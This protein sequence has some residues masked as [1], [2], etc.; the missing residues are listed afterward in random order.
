MTLVNNETNKPQQQK[1][2]VVKIKKR[3]TINTSFSKKPH[4]NVS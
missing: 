4:M 2:Q 3:R 1:E